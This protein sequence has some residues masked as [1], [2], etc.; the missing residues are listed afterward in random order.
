MCIRCGWS[1]V[2]G[3]ALLSSVSHLEVS[4]THSED[5]VSQRNISSLRKRKMMTKSQCVSLAIS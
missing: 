4:S 5:S 2:C 1:E 3:L